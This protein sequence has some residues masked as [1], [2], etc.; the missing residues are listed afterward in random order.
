MKKWILAVCSWSWV[1]WATWPPAWW[2]SRTST[3]GRPPTSTSS[4]WPSL[5]LA[6]WSFPCQRNFILCGGSIRGLLE[7]WFQIYLYIYRLFHKQPKRF[8]RSILSQKNNYVSIEFRILGQ[9]KPHFYYNFRILTKHD[10]S[11]KLISAKF[12]FCASDINLKTNSKQIWGFSLILQ[13]PLGVGAMRRFWSIKKRIESH[14]LVFKFIS[15]FFFFSGRCFLCDVK[16][17]MIKKIKKSHTNIFKFI[18]CFAMWRL[19]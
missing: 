3:W 5:T 19:W 12:T 10:L 15:I 9:T 7:R 8:F 17:V 4:T 11:C 1:S 6:P 2:S 13:V 18:R 16:I 14:N